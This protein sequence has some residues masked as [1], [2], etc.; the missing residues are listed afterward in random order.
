M[1]KFQECADSIIRLRAEYLWSVGQADRICFN[2]TSGDPCCWKAWKSGLRPEAKDSNVVWVK[3]GE[4]VST[5]SEFM[6]YLEKVME[7]AGTASLQRELVH[8]PPDQLSIGDVIIQAGYPGHAVLVVDMAQNRH[9][10]RVMLLGQGFM[11]AQEFHLLRNPGD[12]AS[13]WFKVKHTGSLKTPQWPF[14]M[15]KDCRRFNSME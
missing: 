14:H 8:I 11:P 5:R 12:K 2:F 15:T 6:I 10:G 13:P 1:L 7:Y 3:S 4:A 9:G